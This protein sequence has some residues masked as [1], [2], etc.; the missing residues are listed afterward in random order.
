MNGKA[1]TERFFFFTDVEEFSGRIDDLVVTEVVR[2]SHC[3]RNSKK[4][5][6]GADSDAGESASMKKRKQSSLKKAVGSS[7]SRGQ[8]KNAQG[9][10]ATFFR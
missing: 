8:L 6:D 1:L 9:E 10:K 5:S 3:S 4:R 7:P 2:E